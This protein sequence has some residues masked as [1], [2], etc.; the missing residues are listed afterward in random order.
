MYLIKKYTTHFD[1]Y[2]FYVFK[3]IINEVQNVFS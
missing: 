1:V 3:N 2:V